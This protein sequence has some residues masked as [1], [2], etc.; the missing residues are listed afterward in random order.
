M[1]ESS[2]DLTALIGYVKATPSEFAILQGADTLIE[3]ALMYGAKGAVPATSNIAPEFAVAIY[4]AHIRGDYAAAREAQFR[5]SP[6][7]L[8]LTGTS[9][10]GV[11]SAMRRAGFDC[12][13]SRGP[14]ANVE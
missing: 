4:E 14:I 3:P 5:F 8:G 11:K 7:R 9:P 6:L 2:G 10:G 13:P 12:G 1:K